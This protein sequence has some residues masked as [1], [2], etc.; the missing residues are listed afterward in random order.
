LLG[1]G[2]DLEIRD[3]TDNRASLDDVMRKLNEQYARRGRF[4][5]DSEGIRLAAEEVIREARPDGRADLSEFFR[6]Y[7]AGTDE[8]P[9]ARWLGVAGLR[10]RTSG[11]RYYL[12]EM[13]Q[14]SERQRAILASILAGRGAG[15]IAL[16]AG[17]GSAR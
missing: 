10:L 9:Y 7:V 6:R 11:E 13:P 16:P 17:A 4:Y 15:E 2:L 5:G 12:E 1:V 8:L 14:A 3:A